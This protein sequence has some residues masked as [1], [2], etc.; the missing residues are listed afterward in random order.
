VPFFPQFLSFTWL[1]VTSAPAVVFGRSLIYYY[2][3]FDLKRLLFAADYL[4][5]WINQ[6]LHKRF[7]HEVIGEGLR[8]QA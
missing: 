2:D 8:E 6:E 5:L 7:C 3:Y 1:G 4:L